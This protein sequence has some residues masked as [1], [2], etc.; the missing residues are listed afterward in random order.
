MV[1][2]KKNQQIRICW[3]FYFTDI[4]HDKY[5]MKLLEIP[6]EIKL[7]SIN[8]IVY[9]TPTKG[10][11][12]Y[13]SRR[14]SMTCTRQLTNIPVHE[15]HFQTGSGGGGTVARQR[16]VHALHLRP[17]LVADHRRGSFSEV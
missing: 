11:C 1:A 5:R 7:T 3:F 15:T 14:I 16:A 13:S 2:I 9:V 17:N 6:Q 8:V 4:F 12:G 10:Y